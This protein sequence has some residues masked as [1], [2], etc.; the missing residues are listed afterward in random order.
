VLAG[1]LATL[2]LVAAASALLA[3][4]QTRRA[5]HQTRVAESQRLAL[6][7]QTLASSRLDLALLLGRAGHRLD[8]SDVTERGLLAALS[9]APQLRGLDHRFGT[10]LGTMALHPDGR[11]LAIGGQDGSM[12]LWDER[13]D[14]PL[15]KPVDV[16]VGSVLDAEF[17]PDGARMVVTPTAALACSTRARCASSRRR[18]TIAATRSEPPSRRTAVR[19]RRRR[20]RAS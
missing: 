19:W 9:E 5:R 2:L 8:D 1:V 15:T 14:R 17:S 10:A 7:S 12:R 6:Q 16:G 13:S 11:T 20:R 4:R 18:C 3:A